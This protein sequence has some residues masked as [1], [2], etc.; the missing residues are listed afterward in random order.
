MTP[1]E[2]MLAYYEGWKYIN[3]YVL[4]IKNSNPFTST[5]DIEDHIRVKG[6]TSEWHKEVYL[7]LPWGHAD[8]R[9]ASAEGWKIMSDF[10]F[11]STRKANIRDITAL[12]SS[13]AGGGELLYVKAVIHCAKGKLSL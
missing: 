2:H 8:T 9:A 6:A 13:K 3:G 11:R 1:T 5:Y 4:P 10:S 7:A 12:I